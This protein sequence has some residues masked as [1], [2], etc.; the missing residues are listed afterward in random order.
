MSIIITCYNVSLIDIHILLRCG[1][2]YMKEKF[3]LHLTIILT[4]DDSCKLLLFAI[5]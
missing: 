3:M 4:L 2:S 5:G 1:M